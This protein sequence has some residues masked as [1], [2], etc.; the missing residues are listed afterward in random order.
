MDDLLLDF[1]ENGKDLRKVKAAKPKHGPKGGYVSDEEDKE[2]AKEDEICKI[3]EDCD[4]KVLF[5]TL[6]LV[7][8]LP[9][10][11]PRF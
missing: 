7:S 6:H 10:P 11:L 3:F 5:P 4:K 9:I 8:L 2:E 1:F